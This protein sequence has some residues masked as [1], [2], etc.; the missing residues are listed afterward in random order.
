MDLNLDLSLPSCGTESLTLRLYT[1][2][3]GVTR[4]GLRLLCPWL[5]PRGRDWGQQAGLF[6]LQ[7]F[8]N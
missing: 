5:R 2:P 8:V 4:E 3:R 7:L 1:R 6:L